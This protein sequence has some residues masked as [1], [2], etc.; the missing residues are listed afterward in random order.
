MNFTA[1]VDRADNH[2]SD[3]FSSSPS[4]ITF[5]QQPPV[6]ADRHQVLKENVQFLSNMFN[7]NTRKLTENDFF[8]KTRFKKKTVSENKGS[9]L[10]DK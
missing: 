7:K 10:M 5:H 3:S 2:R 9:G 4:S 8:E 1:R 6:K